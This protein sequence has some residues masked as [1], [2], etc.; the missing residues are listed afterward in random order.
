MSPRVRSVAACLALALLLGSAPAE[1]GCGVPEPALW[2]P[3]GEGAAPLD[4]RIT[5]SLGG[6]ARLL[7]DV[8]LRPRGGLPVSVR[9]RE[10]PGPVGQALI[11]LG[12]DAPLQAGTLYEL[13]A[14]RPAS[15]HPNQRVFGAFTT[16]GQPAAAA[17]SLRVLAARYLQRGGSGLPA[18]RWIELDLSTP[19]ATGS[20]ES[21]ATLFAVWL[22]N[23][24]GELALDAAPSVYLPREGTTLRISSPE[25]CAGRHVPLPA[26]LGRAAIAVAALDAAGHQSPPVRVAIDFAHPTPQPLE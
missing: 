11:Q 24:R 21:D 26:A 5:I 18:R 13:V 15:W 25:L 23:Q 7:R 9:R 6:F 10:L 20:S 19:A 17:P 16:G 3:G 12:P 2:S 8:E 14:R 4:A 22:P 1:A